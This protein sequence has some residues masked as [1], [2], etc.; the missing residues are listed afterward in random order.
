MKGAILVVLL[1]AMLRGVEGEAVP[2]KYAQK[3]YLR[4]RAKNQ[5]LYKLFY[6]NDVPHTLGLEGNGNGNGNCKGNCHDN[7]NGNDNGNDNA[8]TGHGNRNGNCH[9]NCVG[10]E[11]GNYNGNKNGQTTLKS[12]FT[13]NNNGNC[14]GN[15]YHNKMGN[16]NG[17]MNKFTHGNGNNNG[18]CKGNCFH[19]KQGNH[20]GNRDK[21]DKPLRPSS[22]VGNCFPLEQPK[23]YDITLLSYEEIASSPLTCQ[24]KDGYTYYVRPRSYCL[25]IHRQ[26][27]IHKSRPTRLQCND[28]EAFDLDICACNRWWFVDV[29]G[30]CTG[31]SQ[32]KFENFSNEDPSYTE[33]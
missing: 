28:G 1:I 17:N 27:K 5:P 2:F 20:F 6:S 21:Q 12:K 19:Y 30:D 33:D 23:A 32:D 14:F 31:G 11:N 15:C 18:N 4:N 24:S 13:G 7:N 22:C 8:G 10:N 9:G 3:E 26:R 25:T 16:Y 29:E